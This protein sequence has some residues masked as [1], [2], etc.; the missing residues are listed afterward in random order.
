MSA[1][2][3]FSITGGTSSGLT[4]ERL[5]LTIEKDKIEARTP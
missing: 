1:M 5:K 3:V 4:I 2:L